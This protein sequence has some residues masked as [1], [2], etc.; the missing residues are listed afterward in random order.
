[1]PGWSGP[2][3]FPVASLVLCRGSVFLKG[4]QTKKRNARLFIPETLADHLLSPGDSVSVPY[5]PRGTRAMCI[6][7]LGYP[8]CNGSCSRAD[9]P[10]LRRS[11][12]SKAFNTR[13]CQSKCVNGWVKGRGSFGPAS[14]HTGRQEIPA[15]M[16]VGGLV[17]SRPL[18]V[19]NPCCYCC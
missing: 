18:P 12:Q 9:N 8:F 13:L 10:Q 4:C 14:L 3:P 5:I 17:S 19:V 15:E 1:M 16:P 2:S 7:F 11:R 6:A